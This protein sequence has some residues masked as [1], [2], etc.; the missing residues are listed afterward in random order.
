[1]EKINLPKGILPPEAVLSHRT[2]GMGSPPTRQ[3]KVTE[4]P[5]K[6]VWSWGPRMMYGLT[7]ME[8]ANRGNDKRQFNQKTSNQ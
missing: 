5:S 3:G 6:T 8:I 7:A 1:M 2:S 4:A